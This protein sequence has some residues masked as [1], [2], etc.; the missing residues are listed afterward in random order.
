MAPSE[1]HEVSAA[2]ANVAFILVE[3]RFVLVDGELTSVKTNF[4][5]RDKSIGEYI[6]GIKKI[7]IISPKDTV[8]VEG[9]KALFEY[10]K[11]HRERAI[12]GKAK[13]VKITV[14]E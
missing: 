11:K 7:E 8:T 4:A 3:R 12:I 1:Q 5:W 14:K 2:I 13:D 10:L 6:G 9:Q